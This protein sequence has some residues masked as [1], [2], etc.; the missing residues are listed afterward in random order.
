MNNTADETSQYRAGFEH[1]DNHC[2]KLTD[3]YYL[4]DVQD[5]RQL[6]WKIHNAWTESVRKAEEVDA[7]GAKHSVELD[8]FHAGEAAGYRRN[9]DTMFPG[10]FK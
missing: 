9:L 7:I 10:V 1:A 3:V 4:A 6:A 2:R 8:N 5:A